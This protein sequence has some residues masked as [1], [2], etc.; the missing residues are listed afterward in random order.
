MRRIGVP[1]MRMVGAGVGPNTAA[2]RR[3]RW[4]ADVDAE[5]DAVRIALGHGQQLHQAQRWRCVHERNRSGSQTDSVGGMNRM[6]IGLEI[7]EGGFMNRME[8]D[9]GTEDYGSINRCCASSDFF[10]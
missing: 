2:R 5:D 8:I 10:I 6:E 4:V 3:G 1:L 9:F 7:E